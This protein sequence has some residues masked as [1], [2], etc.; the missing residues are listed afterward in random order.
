MYRILDA[1]LQH[2]MHLYLMFYIAYCKKNL[3]IQVNAHNE[4]HLLQLQCTAV[5]H[6]EARG[7]K[8]DKQTEQLSN[9]PIP[10]KRSHMGGLQ[11]VLSLAVGA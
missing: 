2:K 1:I 9:I 10:G 5:V 3:S 11:S 7:S 6:L 4:G 8:N